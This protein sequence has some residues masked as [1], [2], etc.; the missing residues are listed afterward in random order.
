MTRW[1]N[2][3]GP[4]HVPP[5]ER[6]APIRLA[7]P[8]LTAIFAA[9][10]FA[11]RGL[12]IVDTPCVPRANRYFLPGK[13]YHLIHRCHDRQF[14]FKFA[15]NRYRYRQIMWESLDHFAVEVFSYCL[16]SNHTHFLVRSE[17]PGLISQWMQEV[18]GQ[19]AQAYHRRK[20]RSGSFW[21][22]QYHCTMIE[23]GQHLSR[24][25][26]YIELNMVRAGVVGHP[27]QW[28]WCSY[29]EW[30]G[31]RRRYVLTDQPAC[32]GILGDPDLKSF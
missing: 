29:Q 9:S 26:V 14:L 3:V 6:I 25:M 24:C 20:K 1:Q 31:Q 30:M 19:F 32:L 16:T 2:R 23:P 12:A 18:E 10:F 5:H 13:L 21:E 7:F 27:E 22:D 8:L 15:K 4:Q 17:E 11:A 28:P